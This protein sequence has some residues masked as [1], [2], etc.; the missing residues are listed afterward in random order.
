MCTV[1]MHK[2]ERKRPV[3][4]GGDV[5]IVLIHGLFASLGWWM[6]NLQPLVAAFPKRR[7]LAFDWLGAGCSGRPEFPTRTL[8]SSQSSKEQ[9]I[10]DADNYMVS[11]YE[12]WR[13]AEGIQKM[14]LV[15]H[16][17]GAYF[18]TLYA[19]RHP[20]RV[21]KLVLVSPCG[22]LDTPPEL[23]DEDQNAITG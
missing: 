2:R 11:A 21:R 1:E 18:A 7:V 20:T 23:D 19:L 8:L 13:Q 9:T 15:A 22:M 14:D 3:D 16:S 4:P 17:T 10:S 5:P 12:D 6:L